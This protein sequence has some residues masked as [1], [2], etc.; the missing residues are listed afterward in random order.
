MAL[1]LD[2]SKAY[3]RVEWA[4]WRAVLCTMGFDNNLVNMIMACS[5]SVHYN[6][7]HVGQEFGDI[8]PER[9]LRQGDPLSPYLFIAYAEGFS[10]L[11]RDSERRNWLNRVQVV[12]EA[13]I[14]SHML[15]A[16]DSYIFL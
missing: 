16:Y 6:I 10:A 2:M 11:I 14:V 4:Y 5:T 13:L 12:R 3:N 7:A 9:G 8:I 1:K 15:F